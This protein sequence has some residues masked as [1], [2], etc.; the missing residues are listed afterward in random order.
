ML[1]PTV[2]IMSNGTTK[3]GSNE[4][5]AT[6]KALPSLQAT[7][8]IHKNLSKN[9]EGNTVD[10]YIA[11]LDE[12]CEGNFIRLSADPDAKNF[13]VSIPAKKFEKTYPIQ[14]K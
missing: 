9:S 13:T 4:V 11:N 8:Q 12:K 3:G 14:A 2:A 10:E 5:R 6:L 1:K 7:F